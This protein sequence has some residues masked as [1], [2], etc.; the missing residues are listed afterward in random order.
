MGILFDRASERVIEKPQ[1][2]VTR[3]IGYLQMRGVVK[4]LY[5]RYQ[6]QSALWF[7]RKMKEV[8][9]EGEMNEVYKL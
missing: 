1:D 9:N 3:S 6:H 7:Y 4:R 8:F 5:E 2:E